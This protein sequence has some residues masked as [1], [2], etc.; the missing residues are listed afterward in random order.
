M[1]SLKAV[2]F[3]CAMAFVIIDANPTPKRDIRAS[4]Y[5]IDS[6]DIV[7]T[8]ANA[9]GA[10][11]TAANVAAA[12][13]APLANRARGQRQGYGYGYNPY[14]YYDNGAAYPSYGDYYGGP[15][16]PRNNYYN[17]YQQPSQYDYM[18][19][20]Y[21]GYNNNYV[22]RRRNGNTKRRQFRP[23]PIEATS[24]KYTVWDLARK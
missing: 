9:L 24:Q 4:D 7:R 20:Y 23:R 22:N 6:I 17:G 1:S 5:A 3:V 2:Y 11:G 15:S 14:D 19:G 8:A 13:A 21:P 12:T 10:A 16:P 18:Y